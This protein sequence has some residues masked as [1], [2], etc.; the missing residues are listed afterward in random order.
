MKAIRVHEFGNP[1]VMKEEEFPDLQ[2]GDGQVVVAIKA[3]GVNP[4][5]AYIRSGLYAKEPSLPYT[6]GMDGAGTVKSV[7]PGVSA[8]RP[9]QRVY[10]AGSLSGT[11]AEQ[12]VCQA[13]QVHVLP[14]PVSF[15][16]GAALGVPYGVAYRAL[17]QRAVVR[18][19]ETVLVHG[20]TGGVGT[21][22]VQLAQAAGLKVIG[23]AGTPDGLEFVRSQG[24][25]HA[26]DHRDPHHGEQVLKLTHGA[27]V[28]V[29]IEVLANVNLGSDLKMVAY[30]GRIAV[31]GSRGTVEIDPRDAMVKEAAI[32]GVLLFNATADELAIIHSG[33]F[34]GLDRGDLKPVIGQTFP[35][36]D[37]PKAHKAV[38]QSHAFG[39]IVLVP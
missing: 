4:V 31:I 36:S 18:K 19:G 7:G 26:I 27:G 23:T 14:D 5:D 25:D 13:S 10:V 24:A 35:L 1:D 37:A 32:L 28:D 3:A 34:Q 12:T 30:G 20:A 6:P 2:P 29:V 38:L 21:A 8:V 15:E 22:A 33:L 17:F 11:Y 9:G 16:Q 39:K